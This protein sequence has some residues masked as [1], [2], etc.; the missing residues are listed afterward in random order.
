MGD[1]FGSRWDNEGGSASFTS[2]WALEK[3]EP[4]EEVT[5][6]SIQPI[7][8]RYASFINTCSAVSLELRNESIDVIILMQS[9]TSVKGHALSEQSNR[10]MSLKQFKKRPV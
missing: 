8:E 9:V 10:P 7:G 4:K 5:I 1:S 6:S 3:E 2:S